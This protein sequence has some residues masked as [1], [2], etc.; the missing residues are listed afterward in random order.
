MN[1][2]I[3]SLGAMG[4]LFG[5]IL[6]WAAKLF[7]VEVDPRIEQISAILPGAN[8]GGCGYPGCAGFGEALV[9]G[10]AM[11]TKCP[12][13]SDEIRAEISSIL[14]ISTS[15][16]EKKRAICL[17]CGGLDDSRY[18]FHYDGIEDCRAA[19][20]I[21]GGDKGCDYGCLGLGTCASSCPFDAITMNSQGLPVVD[22]EKC[23]ACGICV[24]VCPR[25]LFDLV[26]VEKKVFIKCS[27]NDK[28]A[29]VKALCDTGCIGC[30]ICAKVCPFGA[31]QMV[32]NLAVIDYSKCRN[33][34][35]CVKKCPVKCIKSQVIERAK[36]VITND[37][38]GCTL[39]KTVCPT[40]AIDGEPKEKHKVRLEKCIGCGACVEKCPKN[41]I[42]MKAVE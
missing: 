20:L 40:D 13:S 27:S 7:F 29:R 41:A 18:K 28:G 2:A 16:L 24:H 23:T 10:E 3:L 42:V 9:R 25:N 34:E 12:A 33:C 36:A 22:E 32:N 19:I 6:A 38:I 31:I 11:P 17:C 37:C 39:C 5:V 26:S 21:G 8:C 1:I 4:L 14:G 35:L 15:T 30:G